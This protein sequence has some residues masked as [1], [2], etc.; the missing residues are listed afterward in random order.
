VF[1]LKKRGGGG[2]KIRKM[3]EPKFEGLTFKGKKNT[4]RMRIRC[5]QMVRDQTG[6][7]DKVLNSSL[8]GG[9]GRTPS[10]TS[11]PEEKNT[12]P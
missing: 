11:R 4:S 9:R 10:K 12:M 6:S 1:G 3:S 8:G 2:G 7:A 5:G